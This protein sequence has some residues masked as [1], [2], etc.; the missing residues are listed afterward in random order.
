MSIH[1]RITG[2]SITPALA[3]RI[4]ADEARAYFSTLLII[5]SSLALERE[6]LPISPRRSLLCLEQFWN[7]AEQGGLPAS[8]DEEYA[9]RYWPDLMDHERQALLDLTRRSPF[10]IALES[11]AIDRLV[12]QGLEPT[13]Y[14]LAIAKRLIIRTRATTARNAAHGDVLGDWLDTTSSTEDGAIVALELSVAHPVA[15]PLTLPAKIVAHNSTDPLAHV[16]P[17][18]RRILEMTPIELADHFIEKKHG[19]FAHRGSGKRKASTTGEQTSRQIRCA[20][21]M[22]QQSVPVG[23]T[24]ATCWGYAISRRPA[25]VIGDCPASSQECWKGAFTGSAGP[26]RKQTFR[27]I[28]L[29]LESG[30]SAVRT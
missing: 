24:F 3:Q 13:P 21:R 23:T 16:S 17:D 28:E 18:N 30:R 12:E 9:K 20:A 7:G 5:D 25:V 22:L 14:N 1:Q 15:I 10:E 4:A 2:G 29:K 11:D 6:P 19:F 26:G 27:L 8:I